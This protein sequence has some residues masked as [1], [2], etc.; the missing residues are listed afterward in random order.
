MLAE[1]LSLRNEFEAW[2]EKNPRAAKSQW[3]QLNWF[4][5]KTPYWDEQ[6]DRYPLGRITDKEILDHLNK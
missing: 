6:K 5:M 4:Y 2:K 3:A 1:D